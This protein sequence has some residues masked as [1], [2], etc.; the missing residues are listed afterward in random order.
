MSTTTTTPAPEDEPN[1][2]ATPPPN[3]GNNARATWNFSLEDVRA[4]MNHSTPEHKQILIDCFLWAIDTKHP[5]T[6]AEFAKG[7]DYDQTTVR[8]IYQGKYTNP[9]DGTRL[10]IPAKM[11]AKARAWLSR[12]KLTFKGREEFVLTP[13]ARRIMQYC[14]LARESHTPVWI[15]GRSHLGKTWALEHY[16]E[17]RN[18][19]ASPYIRMKAA[20]GLGGMVRR[21]ASRVGVSE[22][23]NTAGAVDALKRAITS[24]MVVL[25]DELHLLIYTYRLA[26]FFACMEVIREIYDETGCGMVLSGTKLLLSRVNEGARGEMEQLLRR[27]VHRLELPDMPQKADLTAIFERDGL[28]FPDR[29]LIVTVQGVNEKPYEILRQLGKEEGLKAICERLRY[30]ARLAAAENEVTSWRTFVEAHLHI[31]SGRS[32]QNDWED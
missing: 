27:G 22:G 2:A 11:A 18:H 5:F 20:S 31:L 26:S 12:Q 16:S 6:L 1:N 9:K 14:D 10:D 17:K 28:E 25:L 32:I 7:V 21:I 30:A 4:A 15:T 24:D 8:R 19:G 29:K 3:S 23:N 13:T